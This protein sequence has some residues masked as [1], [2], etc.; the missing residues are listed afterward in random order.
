[1]SPV[2]RAVETLFGPGGRKSRVSSDA[3]AVLMALPS[4]IIVLNAG[5]VIEQVNPAAESFLQSSAAML[6]GV[7][8]DQY[9]PADSPLFTL[10]TQA[11]DNHASVSDHGLMLDTPRTGPHLV[12]IDVAPL[13]EAG[14]LV[15]VFQIRSIASQ[16]DRQLMHRGAARSV[17]AM[18][19]MLAHEVKNPL[20]GIRGAAQLLDQNVSAEDRTLTQ[21]IVDETDRICALVDR[22]E[23]FSDSRPPRV[24]P[25]NIHQVLDHVRRLAQNGFA[26]KVR[27]SDRYDPSLPEVSGNRDQLVQVF[28]NLIKNAAEAVPDEGGEILI[29]TAYQHGVRLAVPGRAQRV[30]LPLVVAIQDNGQGIPE[31]LHRHLFDPF[32]TTKLNGSGLGLAL[33]AKVVNDH[34]GV[35]EFDSQPRRT[36]FRVRLPV[37]GKES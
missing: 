27:I 35:V 28:L 12:G 33:V 6:E 17:T 8:L 7:G 30:H 26:R 19:A 25:V 18:A 15:L 9:I 21:L 36:V 16:L 14:A 5:N 11:R 31:E 13:G 4:P 3:G 20:S 24:A 2:L 29:T 10:L 1:M 23:V 34:G 32:V 37:W 22:M